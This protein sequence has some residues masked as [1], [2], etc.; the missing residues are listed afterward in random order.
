MGTIQ[1]LEDVIGLIRR[2]MLLIL[3]VALP[4]ALVS[5]YLALQLPHVW[6]AAAVIQIETPQV[7]DP[8]RDLPTATTSQ[9]LQ[10]IEQRLL[11]R[12]ALN[13][14][15][16][17]HG[18]FADL[19]ALTESERIVLMRESIQLVPVAPGGAA[20]GGT[21]L[22]AL[23]IIVR[24]GDPQV[25]AAVAN[26][27]AES[28]IAMG[29]TAQ[30]ARI[31]ETLAFFAAEQARIGEEL[32]AAEARINAFKNANLESLPEALASRREE[33]GRLDE[34]LR[35]IDRKL[36][37]LQSE[38]DTVAAG[39]N[40]RAVER[41]QIEA[42]DG[43]IAVLREE[44]ALLAQRRDELAEAIGRAPSVEIELARLA[45]ELQ[46]IQEQY[47]V[48]VR[49]LAEVETSRKLAEAAQGER[50][51]LLEP[52]VPPE[53]PLRSE[54]R[55]TLVLG[56]GASGALALLLALVADLRHPV[57]RTPGQMTRAVGLT[58]VVAIP[59]IEGRGAGLRRT[60]LRLLGLAM[61]AAAALA[62]MAM[63]AAAALG[64]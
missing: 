52:A 56:V 51:T 9:R 32:A 15:I 4:G 64:N 58:P 1:T 33:I 20:I 42:L 30:I 61:I 59:Y 10:L 16:A 7:A 31:D 22:S 28:V 19:P 17:R 3:A 40:L 23:V 5:L 26:E 53:Y 8:A 63:V 54:R 27:M 41:R 44:R 38:R 62:A 47:A 13:E 45:R 24:L 34:G 11:S 39:P 48:V 21:D 46:Q 55:K 29:A 2:R 37:E 35:E 50:F 49:R 18:L 60:A 57:L 43:Q 14:L 36:I 12:A 25:A 6:E